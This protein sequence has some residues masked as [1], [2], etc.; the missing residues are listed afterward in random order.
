MQMVKTG[1]NWF[2]KRVLEKS[3]LEKQT[4]NIP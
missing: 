2:L 3:A 1:G 4:E